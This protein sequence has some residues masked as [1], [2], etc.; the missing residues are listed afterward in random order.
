MI[1]SKYQISK[2]ILHL[3]QK[4]AN[5]EKQHKEN[6]DEY[7]NLFHLLPSCI[8]YE[9]QEFL[10]Q[11]M[12]REE[13]EKID[14]YLNAQADI[15][16][17]RKISPEDT[18]LAIRIYEHINQFSETTVSSIPEK[19]EMKIR[20]NLMVQI[21][22][23][24]HSTKL[25]NE[26]KNYLIDYKY[27]MLSTMYNLEQKRL[28]DEFLVPYQ[29]HDIVPAELNN[30]LLPVLNNVCQ[31]VFSLTDNNIMKNTILYVVYMKTMMELLPINIYEHQLEQIYNAI[32]ANRMLSFIS[33]I[34]RNQMC[35][36]IADVLK[37]ESSIKILK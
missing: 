12:T 11:S 14:T 33:G 6:T 35:N 8:Q 27:M 5:L 15:N 22:Q 21:E 19:F 24:L 3:Y 1:E 2:S 9:A 23:Y 7:Q 20:V 26:Q 36:M 17:C 32:G 16:T 25:T 37:T 28:G 30:I 10:N 29:S 13:Y 4:L 34:N 18:Q 31:Y